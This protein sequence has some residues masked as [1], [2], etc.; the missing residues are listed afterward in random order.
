MRKREHF[1]FLDG[2]KPALL[3]SPR[4]PFFE[5]VAVS[6]FPKITPF[7]E[8]PESHIFFQTEKQT[9]EYQRKIKG[10]ALRSYDFYMIVGEN[11][12]FPKRSVEYFA[13]MRALEDKI[14]YYPED[15]RL[16][17]LGIIWAGFFFASHL[18]FAE[19]EAEWLFDTYQHEKAIGLPLYIYDKRI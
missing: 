10:V 2:Y 8:E 14:G 12:G 18:D 16:N 5:D 3:I 11:L 9:E 1:A 17:G 13:K 6:D 15:E 7:D 19:Q 4:S